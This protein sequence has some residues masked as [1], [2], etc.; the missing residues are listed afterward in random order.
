MIIISRFRISVILIFILYNSIF[1][2]LDEEK[3]SLVL[4]YADGGTLEKY[5]RKNATTFK[6]EDQLNFA[7]E[8]AW[9]IL[10]LHDN[11]IIHGDLVR[12][13]IFLCF[14]YLRVNFLNNVINTFFF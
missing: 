6:W 7:K 9:A 10:W 13:F 2:I 4:E 3:Y 8:I 1:F 14:T 5:L 11:N 12:T